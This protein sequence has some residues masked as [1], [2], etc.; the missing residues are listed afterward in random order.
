[1]DV[2]ESPESFE[3]WRARTSSGRPPKAREGYRKLLAV[4]DLD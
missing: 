2:S 3:Q 4:G 1:M